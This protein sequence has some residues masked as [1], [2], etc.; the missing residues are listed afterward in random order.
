MGRPHRQRQPARQ[1]S[2]RPSAQHRRGHDRDRQGRP[3]EEDHRRRQ[4]RNPRTQE[5]HQYAIERFRLGSDPRRARGRHRGQARRPG[6]G[7]GR[8]RHLGRL[9]RQR[10]PAGQQS[11][12]PGAQ[13]RRG[14]DRDRPR[15]LVE[16]D[17][18]RREG[19][20]PRA[21]GHHQH[22]G[23]PAQFV[24]VRGHA[25]CSRGG[26]GRQAR[27]AGSG[28]RRRRHLGRLDRQRQ[29]ARQQ[30]HRPGAQHRR[31]HD[32]DRQG[33]PFEEDHRRR[34]RRNPR[35]Q[36]HHQYDGR[37]AQL[38]RVRSD[39]RRPRSGLGRQARRPGSGR[40]RRRHLG[41]PD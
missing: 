23:R 12:R 11:D 6:G 10:Q 22:D 31:G 20:D 14:H 13:H 41:R 17:H 36:E 32:R 35:T 9:D 26:L 27:R 40:R 28:R 25:R 34:P 3:F 2:D 18:R 7:S 33:R 15:R 4:R 5:H 16:K 1:Q 30:S 29:P 39:P 37:P 24:R 21:Q 38:L 19:R 8:R